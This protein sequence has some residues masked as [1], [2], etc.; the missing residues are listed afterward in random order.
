M[1]DFLFGEAGRNDADHFATLVKDGIGN[2]CHEPDV[3]TAIHKTDSSRREFASKGLGR[4]SVF[5]TCTGAGTCKHTI[6]H[7]VHPSTGY[8]PSSNLT[9]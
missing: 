7:F 2:C 8:G 5:V 9:E 3:R 4:G 6:T 1:R